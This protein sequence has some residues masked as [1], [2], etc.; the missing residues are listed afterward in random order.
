MHRTADINAA[1]SLPKEAVT[2]KENTKIVIPQVVI[3]KCI[4]IKKTFSINRLC[5]DAMGNQLT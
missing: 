3:T 5:L 4:H 1:I 2:G